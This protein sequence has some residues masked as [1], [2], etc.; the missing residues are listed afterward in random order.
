[1]E[2]AIRGISVT[3]DI[4]RTQNSVVDPQKLLNIAAFSRASSRPPD[5]MGRMEATEKSSNMLDS[6]SCLTDGGDWEAKHCA[7]FAALLCLP[8]S[9]RR[10]GEQVYSACRPWTRGS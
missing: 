7:R 2:R 3:V 9:Q 4:I 6:R 5:K 1:M 8:F 10:C